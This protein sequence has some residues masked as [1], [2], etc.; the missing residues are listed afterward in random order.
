[1]SSPERDWDAMGHPLLR[2]YPPPAETLKALTV[3]TERGL[4]RRRDQNVRFVV[5]I[6][7]FVFELVN[8]APRCFAQQ[9][10]P[11]DLVSAVTAYSDLADCGK[12]LSNR[13]VPLVLRCGNDGT[14]TKNQIEQWE[15]GG[16]G[17]GG[18]D[19]R[20]QQYTEVAIKIRTGSIS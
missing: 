2:G 1:M 9:G 18:Y 11:S 12:N 19:S 7:V 3:K 10:L 16:G 20:A 13:T 6:F 14:C 17:G 4:Y 8:L 5:V 15:R